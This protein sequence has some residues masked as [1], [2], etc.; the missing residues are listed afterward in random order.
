MTGQEKAAAHVG[1]TI[2]PLDL[3]G[4]AVM[5]VPTGMCPSAT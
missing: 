1:S 5:D 4:D 2:T 3:N